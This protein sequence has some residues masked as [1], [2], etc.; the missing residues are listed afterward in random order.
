MLFDMDFTAVSDPKP[1]FFR[2]DMQRGVIDL[3]KAQ[4]MG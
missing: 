4:V 2:A 1:Q 3:T